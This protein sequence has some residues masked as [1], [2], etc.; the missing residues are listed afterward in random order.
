MGINR[1]KYTRI[2]IAL[3]LFLALICN[4][5]LIL[6]GDVTLGILLQLVQILSAYGLDRNYTR[7]E[8]EELY[9]LDNIKYK[10]HVYT[11]NKKTKLN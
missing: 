2:T 5:K 8:A 7:D 10:P 1:R 6:K 9:P 11:D 4:I 3:L